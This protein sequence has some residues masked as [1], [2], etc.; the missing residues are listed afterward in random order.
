MSEKRMT[1]LQQDWGR[2]YWGYI[3]C[4]LDYN[5]IPDEFSKCPSVDV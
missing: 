3:H 1:S 4:F 5:A 2:I